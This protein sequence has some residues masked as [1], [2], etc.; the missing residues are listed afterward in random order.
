MRVVTAFG[1]SPCRIVLAGSTK[2]VASLARQS[3]RHSNGSPA[4][5]CIAPPHRTVEHRPDAQS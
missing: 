4:E 2:P 3:N 1:E 5:H